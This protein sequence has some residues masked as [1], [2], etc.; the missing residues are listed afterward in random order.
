MKKLYVDFTATEDV[1]EDTYG[2]DGPYTGYR[3]TSTS[4]DIHSLSRESVETFGEDVEVD[5][6]TFTAKEGYLV[7]VRY[8]TGSTFG[9]ERG[10]Y[11]FIAVFDDLDDAE[12]LAAEI[13][14]DSAA[15]NRNDKWTFIPKT[16]NVAYAKDGIHCS[17]KGYF[18]RLESVDVESLRIK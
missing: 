8:S 18:E 15:G 14:K 2:D 7:V 12:S 4:I 16:P 11:L 9:R 10:K 13:K 1:E 3:E 17:W 6:K 5:D